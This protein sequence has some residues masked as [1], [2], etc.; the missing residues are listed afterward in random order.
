MSGTIFD[1]VLTELLKSFYHEFEKH[2]KSYDN[3]LMNPNY[4]ETDL[5]HF[6]YNL[7]SSSHNFLPV[8]QNFLS[9]LVTI[10]IP[11]R[12]L[13]LL[14]ILAKFN[15]QLTKNELPNDNLS[16]YS[17]INL[18][19]T[20]NHSHFLEFLTIYFLT[21]VVQ[22]YVTELVKRQYFTKELAPKVINSIFILSRMKTPFPMTD[23]ELF[24]KWSYI[25]HHVSVVDLSEISKYIPQYIDEH[26]LDAIILICQHIHANEQF[27]D[28]IFTYVQLYKRKKILTNNILTCFAN[29]ISMSTCSQEFLTKTFD[30]AWNIRS[31]EPI[32][33][34]IIDLITTLFQLIPDKNSRMLNFY[35]N[36]VFKHTA[37]PDKTERCA[38]AFL[39]L[40]RGQIQN[41]RFDLF[42]PEEFAMKAIVKSD[43]LN[44][45]LEFYVPKSQFDACPQIFL[46]ILVSLA[47]LDLDGFVQNFLP[48]ALS[49]SDFFH[50]LTLLSLTH[51][52]TPTFIDKIKVTETQINMIKT[53]THKYII[54]DLLNLDKSPAYVYESLINIA[55]IRCTDED[56]E[57]FIT[58][59]GLKFDPFKSPVNRAASTSGNYTPRLAIA[60]VSRYL[61]NKEDL[62]DPNIAKALMTLLSSHDVIIHF[63]AKSS[64]N[65][66]YKDLEIVL[67]QHCI[68]I[69]LNGT[70]EMKRNALDVIFNVIKDIKIPRELA[71]SIISLSF[72]MM[73]SSL[74]DV[75]VMALC[76]IR[77]ISKYC[78]KNLLK[79]FSDNKEVIEEEVTCFLRITKVPEPNMSVKNVID[80][81]EWDIVASSSY[82]S[83]WK[84]Y[85]ATLLSLIIEEW[86]EILPKLREVGLSISKSALSTDA[87]SYLAMMVSTFASEFSDN[88]PIIS[89]CSDYV[90]T[91]VNSQ[92]STHINHLL[93]ATHLMNY[94]V[95]PTMLNIITKLSPQFYSEMAAALTKI[96]QN[97][98]FFSN[99]FFIVIM[100]I[101]DLLTLFQ[102]YFFAN[103]MC[104]QRDMRWDA[105]A[106]ET[107]KINH[108]MC[109][110]YCTI[111]AAVFNNISGNFTDEEWPLQSR[112]L[113][114]RILIQWVNIPG[115]FDVLHEYAMN[116]LVPILCAGT[117]FT[118][119]FDFDP[120]LMYKLIDIQAEGYLILNYLLLYHPDI[121]M[122]EFIKSYFLEPPHISKMFADAIIQ[123]VDYCINGAALIMHIGPI[124]LFANSI[125]DSNTDGAI[126]VLAKLANFFL[127]EKSALIIQESGSDK[128][129][130]YSIFDF[131]T[132]NVIKFG[133]NIIKERTSRRLPMRKTKTVLMPW[134]SKIK[135]LP[136]NSI[137][138][139]VD[140]F[141]R[142]YNVISFIQELCDI[143]NS[144]DEEN[145]IFFSDL[146]D[147]LIS[148][149]E[150]S[151]IILITLYNMEDEEIKVKTFKLFCEKH[152]D[153]VC[154]FL[155][156]RCKFAYW[157][158]CNIHSFKID[159]IFW[160]LPI[161]QICFSEHLENAAPYFTTVLHFSLL[162]YQV[163]KPLFDVLIGIAGE[164]VGIQVEQILCSSSV[165]Q[166]KTVHS[167]VSLVS[168][169]LKSDNSQKAIETW[170]SEA[171]M[172]ATCCQNLKHATRSM[173]ILWALDS[174][175]DSSFMSL[176]KNSVTF[177]LCGMSFDSF[178]CFGSYMEAVYAILTQ[179]A[180]SPQFAQFC[181][182]FSIRFI[183]I[184]PFARRINRD[185]LPIFMKYFM[186]NPVAI[187]DH[188]DIIVDAC[189]PFLNDLETNTASHEVIEH[190]IETFESL[191]LKIVKV[192]LDRS[193][194]NDEQCET[195]YEELFAEITTT[196]QAHKLLDFYGIMLETSSE[197]FSQSIIN[198]SIDIVKKFSDSLIADNLVQV[199]R[200]CLKK[201]ITLR[202]AVEFIALVSEHKMNI[203]S[204]ES[205][206]ASTADSSWADYVVAGLDSL[207]TPPL[208][209]I[210]ASIFPIQQTN[211]DGQTPKVYPFDIQLETLTLMK[212]RAIGSLH[213]SDFHRW[214]SSFYVSSFGSNKQSKSSNDPAANSDEIKIKKLV[215][216]DLRLIV[217]SESTPDITSEGFILSCEE[218]AK[219]VF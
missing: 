70:Q 90:N 125:Y 17:G 218:F 36:R 85:F 200:C 180:D 162:F 177:H 121:L 33:A 52:M 116:A 123:A 64:I 145:L 148:N 135:L 126:T 210:H 181:F 19:N 154:K 133:L 188:P 68:D 201:L 41:Y 61:L 128:K 178:S 214:S 71:E 122:T 102:N 59:N 91:I 139:N 50:Y 69:I 48:V 193:I 189:I 24:R 31:S 170:S 1:G 191:E 6:F 75:R 58:K 119:G 39:R 93:Q 168:Q 112:Q 8:Y 161:L 156:K 32:K 25:L 213:T 66:L 192:I 109:I 20:T 173:V 163:A 203:T 215:P 21:D 166:A 27:V 63:A 120:S 104:S 158:F 13:A 77:I 107:V 67:I 164:E 155:A 14:S 211:S 76:I 175:L 82:D 151:K 195:E 44:E 171:M 199:C 187:T 49:R 217:I 53:A 55:K 183:S 208:E 11:Y 159:H 84:Y 197:E 202:P 96:I 186:L 47:G 105:K 172:W 149:R 54:Q 132:E 165:E 7:F 153:V 99:I 65:I 157:Y 143:T 35:K 73:S 207:Y 29:L 86:P 43:H 127:S 219:L 16:N 174:P 18:K 138:S 110:S 9:A 216:R 167:I 22:A 114:T 72:V 147:V 185:A 74:R 89:D 12:D 2:L 130:I 196:E 97:P 194:S 60:Y 100:K 169:K 38:R 144:L 30:F 57:L 15:E 209:R 131:A 37:V 95:L 152:S 56:V 98:T 51:I 4:K 212:K 111:V 205:E 92:N 26:N 160:S 42:K 176:I 146:W 101:S 117:I 94:K 103:K 184:A 136:T 5:D 40:I 182:E 87:V 142:M 81:P 3:V 204:L 140:P 198:S 141:Y 46:E 124:I 45:F 108:D 113:I 80:I 10:A 129:F 79:L 179:H 137:I 190:C 150:N 134:F 62:E 106:I 88:N 206:M 78:S 83:L 23:S 28:S 34:G 118:Q 115:N